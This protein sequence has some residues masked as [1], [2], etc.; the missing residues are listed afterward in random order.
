ATQDLIQNETT[1]SFDRFPPGLYI[2]RI[3]APNEET[4]TFKLIK[5]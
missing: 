3:R 4:Q 2:I 5:R 1:L